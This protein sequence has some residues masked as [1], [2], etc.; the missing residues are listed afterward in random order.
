MCLICGRTQIQGKKNVLF[1]CLVVSGFVR[2]LLLPHLYLRHLRDA[3]WQELVDMGMKHV[4]FDK[5]NTITAPYSSVLDPDVAESFNACVE[6]FGKEN[7]VIFSNTAGSPDDKGHVEAE[8]LEKNFGVP[9]LRHER[10][11]PQGGDDLRRKFKDTASVVVVGDRYFTDILFANL[12]GCLSIYVF[13]LTHKEN[14]MVSMAR[15]LENKWVCKMI[16]EGMD[17]IPHEKMNTAVEESNIMEK[18]TK[19]IKKTMRT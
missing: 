15:S 16:S 17:P 10:R 5:D 12:N 11:K 3:R 8:G 4:V 18:Q 7:V 9:V 14:K 19:E 13:P 2:R 6:A 1:K